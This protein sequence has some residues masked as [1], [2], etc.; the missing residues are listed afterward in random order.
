[1]SWGEMKLK[2][3]DLHTEEVAPVLR[4]NIPSHI[5]H[6][7]YTYCISEKPQNFKPLSYTTLWKILQECPAT[8]RKS[9]SGLDDIMADGLSGFVTLQKAVDTLQDNGVSVD[10]CKN[11]KTKLD[12]AKQYLK[13][14]YSID[15]S[16][17][18]STCADHCRAFA[19]S[20]PKDPK[21]RKVCD[22]SH[23]RVCVQCESMKLLFDDLE[24]EASSLCDENTSKEVQY[25]LSLGIEQIQEW[26]RHILRSSQQQLGKDE[27]LKSLTNEKALLITDWGMKCLPQEYLGKSKNWY[28]KK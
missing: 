22:H 9:L 2:F 21:L 10:T 28:G 25:D 24:N 1:M 13:G 18:S 8:T 4:K 5:I 15:V 27:I 6:L 14:Q 20:D 7:Y 17:N 19:L 16:A 26:K 3:S 12:E 23:D 11:Y